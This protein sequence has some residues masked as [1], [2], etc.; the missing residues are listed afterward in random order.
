MRDNRLIVFVN[1]SFSNGCD[2]HDRR[3]KKKKTKRL[4]FGLA[5]HTFITNDGF[6]HLKMKHLALFNEKRQCSSLLERLD[7]LHEID[8]IESTSKASVI[9]R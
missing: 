3:Q 5:R 2:L 8:Q 7:L 4:Y 1:F 6:E 9:K